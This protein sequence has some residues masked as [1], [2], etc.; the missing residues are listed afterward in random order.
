MP[1]NSEERDIK[2]IECPRDAMQ[3][4]HD[5]IPTKLKIDYLNMLMKVG[6]HTI[7]CG[8][9]VSARAIPQMR[10]SAEVIEQIDMSLS[11]SKLSVI[12]ANY[13]GALDAVKHSNISYLG[14]P[15]SISEEFQQ[16]NT[17]KSI[18]ESVQLV[19]D[20]YELCEKH[21]KEMVI[22]ISMGFGNPY[23]EEWNSEIVDHWVGVL[24]EIGLNSFSISDTVGVS[25]RDKI[26]QVYKSLIKNYKEAEFGA[27]FHT[28]IDN[29]REKVDAAYQNGCVRFDGAIKGYG[30]CPMANDDLV[31]NMP[32]EKLIEY[33]GL[34]R[35]ELKKAPFEEAF[36]YSTNVFK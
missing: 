26:A 31:G 27:H 33:F 32:T 16:R 19:E 22:Y 28:R 7:D 29:W 6:F 1:T 12:V 15:F 3:G 9:F 21:N 24:H 17:N 18:K 20:I 13:R 10:D 4:I 8:S 34:E 14:Y 5:F 30:G 25:S 36:K 11:N 35:L 2:I 23:G